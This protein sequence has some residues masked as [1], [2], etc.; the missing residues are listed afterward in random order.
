MTFPYSEYRGSRTW[1]ILSRAISALEG[2]R[3]LVLQT[4]KEYVVGY[5][6]S[7]LAAE[8]SKK[9]R[10]AERVVRRAKKKKPEP[11]QRSQRNASTMSFSTSVSAV[12]RG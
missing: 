8:V 2:N 3:D 1:Q 4:K 5:L 9:T 10:K 11:N 12:R 7:K 6:A